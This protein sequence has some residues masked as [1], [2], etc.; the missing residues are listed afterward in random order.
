MIVVSKHST[1]HLSSLPIEVPAVVR[2]RPS[3]RRQLSSGRVVDTNP[4][5]RRQSESDRRSSSPA[6]Q[7]DS[8][9]G[10][11]A[12]SVASGS[13]LLRLR[14]HLGRVGGWV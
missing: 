1:T 2:L 12:L 13:T 8:S 3:R 14:R 10:F 4:A 7:E 6:S 5:E 11:F 9:F